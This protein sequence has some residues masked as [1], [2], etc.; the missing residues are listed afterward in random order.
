MESQGKERRLSRIRAFFFSLGRGNK[1]KKLSTEEET[2]NIDPLATL[3]TIDWSTVGHAYGEAIDI[4]DELRDLAAA[5]HSRDDVDKVME[6]FYATIYH[7]GSRYSAT[8]VAIPFLVKILA[9]EYNSVEH[10]RDSNHHDDADGGGEA[11][12]VDVRG[13]DDVYDGYKIIQL[14]K[15]LVSLALGEPEQWLPGGVDLKTWKGH[16]KQ[17]EDGEYIA[18]RKRELEEDVRATDEG[19]ESKRKA[20]EEEFY[21]NLELEKKHLA[22]EIGSYDAVRIEA[23]PEF[24]KLLNFGVDK[25]QKGQR[26]SGENIS[27][28]NINQAAIYALA[29]FPEAENES[30]PAIEALLD[31]EH[32]PALTR[33]TAIITYGLLKHTS[34]APAPESPHDNGT[35]RRIRRDTSH[36]KA[37][38]RWAASVALIGLNMYD[39]SNIREI[40][41]M[42]HDE[43]YRAEANAEGSLP[44]FHGNL[45]QYT[46]SALKFCN[47]T[48]YPEVMSGLLNFMIQTRDTSGL[49]VVSAV[50]QVAFGQPLL[51]CGGKLPPLSDLTDLQRR[52]V[53]AIAEMDVTWWSLVN[54]WMVLEGWGLPIN[55]AAYLEYI[56]SGVFEDE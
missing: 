8:V 41:K 10:K 56:H 39:A 5:K 6:N 27:E 35:V 47:L 46:S 9:A 48:D 4:P 29:W 13:S 37:I 24:L 50:L 52:T 28:D 51:A 18:M 3:D 49:T 26:C 22:N 43:N 14:I 25:S 32:V 12:R 17:L 15:L 53:R 31:Q 44:F 55:R 21:Q 7:Q 33:A 30:I 16:A 42:L 54:F 45:I 2:S 11:E 1:T 40:G 36:D 19:Q 23:V 20:S 38:V 34:T